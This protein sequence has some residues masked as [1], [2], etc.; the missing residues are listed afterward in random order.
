MKISPLSASSLLALLLIALPC[1]ADV[2]VEAQT[3]GQMKMKTFTSG[4]KQRMEVP[5][6]MTSS[7]MITIVRVDKGVEWKVDEKN[8]VYEEKPIALP[9]GRTS[10]FPGEK[11]PNEKKANVKIKKRDGARTIA[12]HEATGYE[13]TVDNQPGVCMWMAPAKGDL[14]KVE[15][16]TQQYHAAYY[17]KQNENQPLAESLS[18]T[19]AA[20]MAMSMMGGGG[21]GD[22]IE[23]L[24][25]LPSGYMM[26]MEMAMGGAGGMMVYEVTKISADPV[27]ASLFEIPPG[28]TKVEDLSQQQ[29]QD[30]MKDLNMEELMKNMPKF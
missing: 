16:E 1:Q 27:Q 24:K 17:K 9:K 18:S 4:L 21:G 12:G 19:A 5:N 2:T 7:P 20:A 10:D 14:A 23:G 13:V 26:G 29:M 25:E 6:P 22:W 15:K 30:M 28:F 8:K 11:M 3:M